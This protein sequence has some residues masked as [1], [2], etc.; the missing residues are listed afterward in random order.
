VLGVVE[1]QANPVAEQVHR[2]LE[3]GRQY[4]AGDSSQL[5]FI[6]I[7]FRRTTFSFA[8]ELAHQVV[9]G[10]T[11]QLPKVRVQPEVESGEP[12]LHPLVLLPGKPEIQTGRG[13]FTEFEDA[14]PIAIGHAQHVA[15]DRHR[16]LR[17]VP[18]DDVDDTRLAGQS[19]QQRFSG[20]FD[21]VPQRGDGPRG[22]HR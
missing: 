11:A 5:V 2:R 9:A 13:K 10:R 19:L 6:Q 18:V 8:N 1:Q 21:P 16:K 7:R 17:A 14:L 3:P 4:Q 20:L 12:A 22:E 15:D